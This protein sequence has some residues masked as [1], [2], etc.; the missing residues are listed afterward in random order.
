MDRLSVGEM[1]KINNISSQTLRL[2]DRIDLLK[3]EYVNEETGYRYYSIKQSA[4]LDMIQYMKSIGMSLA[5]IK[6]QLDK[7]DVNIVKQL[8]ESHKELIAQQINDLQRTKNAVERAIGN[9]NRYHSSPKD[10]TIVTEYIPKRRIYSY[11]S[12]INFYNYGIEAYEMMLRE[13]KKHLILYSLPVVYFCNV[14]T[15]LRLEHLKKREFIS[16]EAFLFV[17]DDFNAA[18]KT[19]VIK[20]NTFL[21]IYCDSFYK[22]KEYANRLL[23]YAA[24]RGWSI[25][26]DYMCE[27]VAEL[28][29]FYYNERNMFIKLQ[30]P[31]SFK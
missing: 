27:V 31:I 10:G 22:E 16:T 5:E 18:N 23:D 19:S 20:E 12:G 30:V 21:C 3:P 25:I 7:Q 8:L 9:Y 15:I 6:E 17:D 11:E 2:Y 28:P 14:G 4:K 24:N 1:A 29:A 13:L 26:G